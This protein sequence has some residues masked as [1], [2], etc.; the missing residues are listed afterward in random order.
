MR[1]LIGKIAILSLV[2]FIFPFSPPQKLEHA[3]EERVLFAVWSPQKGKQPYAYLLD[4][5]AR[6]HGS[7]FTIP[8]PNGPDS[9]PAWNE[10]IKKYFKKGRVYPLLF[11]GSEY[12]SIAVEEFT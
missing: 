7:E 2:P 4:P 12:G 3:K 1:N 10:F 9:D 5:I 8:L 11:G 6:L